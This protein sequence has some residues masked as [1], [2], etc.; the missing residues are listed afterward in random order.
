MCLF[1]QLLLQLGCSSEQRNL[2]VCKK[3][4]W[5]RGGRRPGQPRQPQQLQSW[6]KPARH[7]GESLKSLEAKV[8]DSET[9]SALCPAQ[10]ALLFPGPGLC[11]LSLGQVPG[12]QP[13]CTE[14]GPTLLRYFICFF[15]LY[16]QAPN[17]H[18]AHTLPLPPHTLSEKEVSQLS[19]RGAST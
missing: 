3:R 12:W 7:S 5:Q 6:P 2:F 13:E 19:R 14:H 15:L 17:R 9:S 11:L 18:P 1:S 4:M 16:R 8:T 10:A